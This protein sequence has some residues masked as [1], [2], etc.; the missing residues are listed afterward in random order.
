M[1]EFNKIR[2]TKEIFVDYID[3]MKSEWKQYCLLLAVFTLPFSLCGSYFLL[4]SGYEIL[5]VGAV[6]EVS[7]R[8]FFLALGLSFIAKFLAITVSC[9][10]IHFYLQN[11]KPTIETVKNYIADVLV[12]ALLSVLFYIGM[13]A[14]GMFLFI[15][16]AI[17]MYPAL[18]MLTYD[19]LFAHQPI[20]ASFSRCF[21][22]TRTNPLQSY[23]V[24]LICCVGVLVLSSLFSMIPIQNTVFD[25]VQ[26]SVVSVLSETTMIPF[27]FLYYSLANQNLQS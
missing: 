21:N 2:S 17:I 20:M 7:F 11:V 25:I 24:A 3:F 10:Y 9:A 12:V 1:I 4:Q 18:T 5:L 19:V 23:G 6:G 8:N 26:A 22:L 14:L 13:E 27:V 16:P 15:I